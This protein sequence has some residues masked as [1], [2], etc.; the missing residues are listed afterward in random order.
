[1][2]LRL[3]D[4]QR[5]ALLTLLEDEERLRAEF[6]AVA[7]YLEAAPLLRGTESIERDAAFDLAFAHALTS[8]EGLNPYWSLVEPFI[9]TVDGMPVVDGGSASGSPRLAFAAT[10]LQDVFAHAIPAPATIEWITSISQ[11]QSLVD[12]GA[13][14]GYWAAHLAAAGLRVSAYDIVVPQKTWHQV[15]ELEDD[16]W[17]SMGDQVLLLCWP[18]GWGD[19]MAST[20][21]DKFTE[22]GG[23]RLIYIGEPQ[24][25]KTGNDTFFRALASNWRLES[26]DPQFVRW[27]NMNDRAEYWVRP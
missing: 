25:G 16:L 9:S 8:H 22:S 11:G 24:G 13:G 3:T 7:N 21:I 4:S 19:P 20:V 27:W 23:T 6:P 26:T 2:S 1:M 17:S 15:K 18:P 14:R 12:I 10:I 5:T